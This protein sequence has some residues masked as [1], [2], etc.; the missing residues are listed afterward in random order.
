M[1][2]IKLL[3]KLIIYYQWFYYTKTSQLVYNANPV[4]GF[5]VTG[6]LRL[7]DWS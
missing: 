5:Y 4:T 6:T 1:T 3:I 7:E 2:S